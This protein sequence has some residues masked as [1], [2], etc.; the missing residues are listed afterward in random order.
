MARLTKWRQ[1]VTNPAIEESVLVGY[2][3]GHAILRDGWIVTSRVKYIDR[4]KA[5][6]CTCNTMY[7]LGGELDPREPLPSEVQY[8]VFNMLCRNLV[9][10][11]YKLDL[12]MILKTIEEISRPLLVDD[13]GTKIQ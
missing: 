9:K 4:A 8:A 6:A 1:I 3:H 13:H 12:G 2:C 10:R 5:Q 7:D 11:G